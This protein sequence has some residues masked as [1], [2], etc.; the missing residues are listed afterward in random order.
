MTGG[1]V[2]VSCQK[3]NVLAV[4]SGSFLLSLVELWYESG[5]SKITIFITDLEPANRAELTKLEEYA[6]RNDPG[7]SLHIL[8]VAEDKKM[9]WQMIIQPFDFIVYVSQ[10]GNVEKLQE[11][12]C[13]CIVKKKLMLPAVIIREMGMVG[14]LL[15]PNGDGRWESAWRGLHSSVFLQ[16]QE[17][18][19]FPA[20]A[21]DVLSN[22][23]VNEYG[24]VIRG[25]QETNC[26]NQCYI[27]NPKTLTGI[28]HLIRPHPLVCGVETAHLVEHI[29]PYLEADPKPIPSEEW[30]S[31]FSQL[32]SA[33]TGIFHVWEEADLI[34]LPLAQCL[35]QP[36]DPLSGGPAELMP[37]MIHSG[38][39]HEEARRESGLAGLEAY[40]ARIMPLLFSKAP[41]YPRDFI[42]IGAG[43]TVAEAIGRGVV[44]CLT[45]QLTKQ[46]LPDELA[47]S[48]IECVEIEDVRCRYYLQALTL[49]EGEPLL[50]IGEPL[51][52]C[53][54]VW[55]YSGSLWYGYVELD[56]TLALCKCL[57]KALTKT[58]GIEC[59]AVILR[60]N[61]EQKIIVSKGDYDLSK[62][63]IKLLSVV[64]T[65]KKHCKRFETFDM[66]SESFLDPGPFVIYGV[67][68]VRF[69]QEE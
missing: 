14:P 61:K 60:E 18:Q 13:A 10:R 24:K 40:A 65:L 54:V 37:V 63:T 53:P 25:E 21:V 7:A 16:E 26:R 66:R 22:L 9:E 12:Q 50:A 27:L 48:R 2:R 36:V 5:L 19:G 56:I 15:H 6:L 35:V 38:L 45:Q 55:V 44:A 20:R 42:G 23:I 68:L 8:A 69:G 47:I 33:T 32:T 59:S 3:E 1:V 52:G 64:Q 51:F 4:G 31:Y 29:N 46:M 11:L 17:L 57:Q 62:Y 58:R 67:Q 41:S 39:T 49:T 43:C 28:W 30:F 34:Q